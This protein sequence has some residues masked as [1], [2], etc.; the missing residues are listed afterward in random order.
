LLGAALVR[1]GALEAGIATLATAL[2][3]APD[4]VTVRIDHAQALA[5]AGRL[6]D[7]IA[8]LEDGRARQPDDPDLAAKLGEFLSDADRHDEA[9]EVLAAA[10]GKAPRHLILRTL[11][12]AEYAASLNIEEALAHLTCALALSPR[13]SKILANIGVLYQAIGDLDAAIDYYRQS[14][15]QDPERQ[16][17]RPNLATALLTKF[18][19]ET[20]F[21][22][23]ES[24]LRESHI[25]NP[26]AD[27]PRWRGDALAGR[28]LLVTAEQG[29]GDM[30]QYARFL[31]ALAA[32]GGHVTVECPPGLE[33]LFAMLS[34]VDRVVARDEPLP[35]ADLAIPLLSVPY[36]Q[37]YAMDDVM[38]AIPY[39]AVPPGVC[40]TLP[41]EGLL[42]VG[43]VWAGRPATGE[44]Y[45]RRSL[46][47]RRCPL[48]ALAPLVTIPGARF[49][50]LQVG[51][52]AEEISSSGLSLVDLSGHLDDFADTAAAI[53]GMDLIISIDTATAH[54][55]G[56]MGAPLWVMLAPGQSDY[57]WGV[58]NSTP[59]YP[60]ARLFRAD[61]SGGWPAVIRM[62][63]AELGR[64]A[65]LH[66]RRQ[67][68][69][70]LPNP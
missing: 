46:N 3:L 8:V 11:L 30:L 66:A 16:A 49:F 47:R 18:D 69:S 5:I 38:G 51:E 44:V 12:A 13:N 54:L 61:R 10:V 41:D 23:F 2:A 22:E 35:D 15:A 64:M 52:A 62:M 58:G 37:G 39:L 20:G 34:G 57:R 50:S 21:A 9:E 33:R 31:P 67:I 36:V 26:T 70:V 63:T 42:K 27:I 24:R 28:R 7:G 45:L 14:I 65:K 4:D 17:A 48:A 60:H 68:K 19:F 25:R 32:L 43:L 40:F 56:A 29:Y 53:A 6:E 59:W 55:A 1:R